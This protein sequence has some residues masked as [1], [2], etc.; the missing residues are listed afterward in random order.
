[1]RYLH[2]TDKPAERGRARLNARFAALAQPDPEPAETTN[3][4]PFRRTSA[5]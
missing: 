5:R 1:L 2:A 4:V 3:V